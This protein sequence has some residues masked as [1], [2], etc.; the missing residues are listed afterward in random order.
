MRVAVSARARLFE[1]AGVVWFISRDAPSRID[2]YDTRGWMP[3]SPRLHTGMRATTSAAAAIPSAGTRRGAAR[4]AGPAL[5]G[6]P[7]APRRRGTT[8]PGATGARGGPAES[9]GSSRGSRR[10]DGKEEPPWALMGRSVHE[11][12]VSLSKEQADELALLAVCDESGV[13]AETLR[14]ALKRLEEICPPLAKRRA[15]GEVKP[16][17][18]ARL[19]LDLPAV[20]SGMLGIKR[21]LPGADAAELC[22]RQTSLFAKPG[23]DN[24]VDV[25]QHS[26]RGSRRCRARS[27]GVR[28]AHRRRSRGVGDRRGRRGNDRRDRRPSRRASRRVAVREPRRALRKAPGVS[29]HQGP[30]RVQADVRVR[31]PG[32][33]RGG[34]A[35]RRRDAGTKSR[36]PGTGTETETGTGDGGPRAMAGVLVRVQIREADAG[37][38]AERLRRGQ[39]TDGFP[40]HTRHGR[41]RAVRR[42]EAGVPGRGTR[43]CAAKKPEHIL[44][45]EFFPFGAVPSL[46]SPVRSR[47]TWSLA[48]VSLLSTA[49]DEL[50]RA[51]RSRPFRAVREEHA[52]RV[53]S[54]IER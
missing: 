6:L 26:P 40:E 39:V 54:A 24:A 50:I 9:S 52:G 49:S 1:R 12:H 14:T 30:R 45:G 28:R 37:A 18:M 32:G 15:R 53:A 17:E 23:V 13:D 27:L 35:S 21:L 48:P 25:V 31:T 20:T 10:E 42:L 4:S 44:P 8:A 33:S 38:D 22:A 43:G 16:A 47:C 36:H 41:P 5:R 51:S 7:S 34:D 19:A 29:G 46:L 3:S 2:V 11:H